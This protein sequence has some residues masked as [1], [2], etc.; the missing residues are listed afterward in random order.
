MRAVL[1]GPAGSGKTQTLLEHAWRCAERFESVTLIALPSQRETLLG[2]LSE[3]P[4]LG[5]RLTDLQTQMYEIL[6]ASGGDKGLLSV[7]ARVALVARVLG[8]VLGRSAEPGEAALYALSIAELK[9]SGLEHVPVVRDPYQRTLEQTLK[10]YNAELEHRGLL[11]PDDVRTEAIRLLETS[12]RAHSEHSE[13]SEHLLVDGYQTLNPME[14]RAIQALSK[15]CPSLLVTLPSRAPQPFATRLLEGE[16]KAVARFLEAKVQTLK[17]RA[18][19]QLSVCAYPNAD[20][21]A[22]A[23]LG[24][25]KAALLGLDGNEATDLHTLALIVPSSAY[26][27]PLL[28]VASEYGVPLSSPS[29]A[30]LLEC[31]EG[32]LFSKLLSIHSRGYPLRDLQALSKLYRLEALCE[33]L[34]KRGLG[35]DGLVFLERLEELEGQTLDLE[36]YHMLVKETTLEPGELQGWLGFVEGLLER[37]SLKDRDGLRLLA[38]EVYGLLEVPRPASLL[39]WMRALLGE[40]QVKLPLESGVALLTP[41]EASG[42]RFE[43]VWLLGALEGS[44]ALDESEDFFFAEEERGGDVLGGLKPRMMGRSSSLLYDALWRGNTVQISYPSADRGGNLRGHPLLG[45]FENAPQTRV[46]AA[47]PLEHTTRSRSGAPQMLDWLHLPPTTEN[48]AWELSKFVPCKLKGH[49]SRRYGAKAQG[50]VASRGDLDS[51]RRRMRQARWDEAELPSPGQGWSG[52][53]AREVQEVLERGLPPKPPED[54][55][56]MGSLRLGTLHFR[57]HAYRLE[58]DKAS[59]QIFIVHPPEEWPINLRSHPESL[60]LLETFK[61]EAGRGARFEILAWD[62][63]S[64]PRTLRATDWDVMGAWKQL[65]GTLMALEKGDLRPEPGFH[66]RGCRFADVCRVGA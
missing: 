39:A 43:R 40:V 5:V 36:P 23:A 8:E 41:E 9:R 14:L 50:G 45:S 18:T 48:R 42:S 32:V 64:K 6:E 38:R 24:Q 21:E 33:A 20:S 26:K 61:R 3:K 54:V 34:D 1:T 57:P 37:V 4:S 52:A 27:R 60:W 62:L 51:L 16:V 25:V 49:L 2:R 10:L 55:I 53:F 11:D 30:P 66:C 28:E 19:P 63:L 35:G 12:P 13:H 59:L 47:S 31:A 29:Q 46:G 58:K 7:P 22:R 56:V 65:E 17:P 15:G 44:Y